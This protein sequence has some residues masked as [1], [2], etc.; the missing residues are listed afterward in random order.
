MRITTSKDNE[1]SSVDIHGLSVLM[2]AVEQLACGVV[3]WLGCRSL[4][5]RLSLLCAPSVVSQLGW[6]L[7]SLRD[8]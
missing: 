3:Q 1:K 6:G 7:L 2:F 4:A 5:G 8:R